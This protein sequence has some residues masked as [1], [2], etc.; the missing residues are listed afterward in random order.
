[1]LIGIAALATCVNASAQNSYPNK[2]ITIVVPFGPGSGTDIATR[3]IAQQLGEAMKTTVIVDNKPG[4]NGS[5]AAEHVL[6]ARPDGYTL[7]MGTNSTHGANPA[8]FKNIRYD[9]VKDFEPVNR[10]VV[11]TSIVAIN[12]K[13]P[14]NTMKE[15]IDF[16][17]KN[18]V[19]LAVG[20]ATGTV[21][22][23]TLARAAGWKN[24]LRVTFRSNP[25]AMA[26][27]MAGRINMMFSDIAAAQTQIKAGT[28]KAIAVTSK[29]RSAL[30]PELPTVM[31]SGIKDFDLSG[32]N[33]LFA[34]AGTPK[35]IVDKL[36][37]EI[38]TILQKP[39]IKTRFEEMGAETGP[40]TTTEFKKWV[41]D[42]VNM[43]TKLVNEA[44]IKFG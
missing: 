34:P 5:I 27:V 18:E 12:P 23:E 30:M 31:E 41:Q 42:E 2:P 22:G 1:M 33:A 28:L 14:V 8:L 6:N 24:L 20:N 13:L 11:F 35:E 44:N 9:P 15:L 25:P 16:G 3:L 32:W 36:N 39:Q 7:I 38:T 37:R 21:Q 4:A 17:R 43:W 26:E 19:T 40:L 29:N 10:I